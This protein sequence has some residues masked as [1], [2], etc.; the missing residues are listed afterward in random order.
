MPSPFCPHRSGEVCDPPV[1]QR[2]RPRP[3][4]H[5]YSAEP[6]LARSPLGPHALLHGTP[7][8]GRLCLSLSKSPGPALL[9]ACRLPCSL[10]TW[11]RASP[12][13]SSP[14]PVHFPVHFCFQCNV[15]PLKHLPLGK[16]LLYVT[17]CSSCDRYKAARDRQRA[18]W[19][20]GRGEGPAAAP[21]GLTGKHFI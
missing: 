21:S 14:T 5:W 15:P 18:S 13:H 11:S 10:P 3:R 6:E 4:S 17:C 2:G 16:L 7:E 12:A 8:P 20:D 9:S 1:A 19:L